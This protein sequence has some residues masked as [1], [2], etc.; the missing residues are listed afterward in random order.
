MTNTIFESE[1][2][3]EVIAQLIETFAK[4]LNVE[5]AI[6]TTLK[7]LKGSYALLILDTTSPEVLYAAK[8]K[9]PLI[10]GQSNE[11]ITIASD[12]M[13]LVGYADTYVPIE[14][15]TFIVSNETT[16]RFYDLDHHLIHPTFKKIELDE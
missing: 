9:S 8:H 16:T 4:N 1:T 7:L 14:D 13:A 11:G 12:L 2:D 3:T 15:K 5:N 10:L 6:L